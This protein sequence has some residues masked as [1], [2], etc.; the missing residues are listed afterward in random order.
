MITTLT[1]WHI[2]HRSLYHKAAQESLLMSNTYLDVY[3][4]AEALARYV[5]AAPESADLVSLFW[6]PAGGKCHN[7]SADWIEEASLD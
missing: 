6:E 7:P 4:A 2:I 3:A 1:H 5:L